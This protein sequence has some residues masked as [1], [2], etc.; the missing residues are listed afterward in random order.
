MSLAREA[1]MSGDAVASENYY[2]HAE[3]Y[4]RVMAEKGAS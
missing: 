4:H 3:H 2:Q 1:E